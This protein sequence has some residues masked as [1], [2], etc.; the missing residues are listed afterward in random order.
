MLV[1]WEGAELDYLPAPGNSLVVSDNR[2]NVHELKF[3]IASQGPEWCEEF[4]FR[5]RVCGNLGDKERPVKSGPDFGSFRGRR[6]WQSPKGWTTFPRASLANYANETLLAEEGP[7]GPFFRAQNCTK[8][9]SFF[10]PTSFYSPT[11]PR[12]GV[13]AHIAITATFNHVVS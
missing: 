2:I 5:E 9:H 8:L 1:C 7:S 12:L 11:L 4:S 10:L 6:Q 13:F 3:S